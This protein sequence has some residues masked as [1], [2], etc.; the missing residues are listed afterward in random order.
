MSDRG[1]RWLLIALA[2]ALAGCRERE[3]EEER[4]RAAVPDRIRGGAVVLDARERA[5][6]DL[7][8]E[9]AAEADLP[10][11]RVR[12]GRV[13]TRSGDELA[14]TAPF[15]GR[16]TTVTATAIGEPV[17]AGTT[18]ATIT[19]VLGAADRAALGVQAADLRG[20]IDQAD[21]E[22]ALRQSELQR[23]R[24]L[25]RDSII[26]QAKLQE[27]ETAV[28]TA[29]ARLRAARQSRVAQAGAAG[30]ATALAAPAAGTLVA[31]DAVVGGA[32]EPG[33]VV[34]RLLRAG[35]RRVDVAVG[36]T[37]PS[38]TA[39]EVEVPGGWRPA[40]L[41]ARGTTVG[42]D[43]GRHDLIELDAGAEAL[44]GA[45]V[46]VRLAA[47][48]ARGVVVPE[49]AVLPA[50]GGDVVYVEREPGVFEARS[51]RVAARF[52]GKVRLASGV[53][54][55]DAVVV[56]GA[57]ALRGEALRSSLGEDED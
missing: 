18:I 42:N 19:P 43:G 20:Q 27:A 34:A 25:A 10:D 8:V 48:A 17:A 29:E 54:A 52:A 26:S 53:A 31:L 6:L 38:A 3:D 12:Y 47:A 2:L 46:A 21:R 32:V 41:I 30:R 16:V 37:D 45:T 49:T 4:E 9:K 23:S 51:V 28:A 24:E 15:A 57:A 50:A 56:R 22:L 44:V 11:V 7:G 14:I 35:P 36:A 33:R 55:G 39:Y 40:R 1:T 13:V 5:A